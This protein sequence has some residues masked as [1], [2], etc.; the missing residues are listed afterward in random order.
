MTISVINYSCYLSGR[1]VSM[2]W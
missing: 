2:W 1:P